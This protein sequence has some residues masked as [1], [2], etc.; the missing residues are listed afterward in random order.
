MTT[1][2][3][4]TDPKR[5]AVVALKEAETEEQ[6]RMA[7]ASLLKTYRRLNST[8]DMREIEQQENHNHD[9][10][11]EHIPAIIRAV[12]IAAIIG[13]AGWV[14]SQ[15]ARLDDWEPAY[16]AIK[17]RQEI[18]LQR[19]DAIEASQHPATS[20]RYTADDANRDR[21]ANIREHQQLE[22]RILRLEQR[23]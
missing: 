20:R 19:L 4:C 13:L 3:D 22:Q 16:S 6:E 21:E 5:C 12:V 2:E 10:R 23:K 7:L 15:E 8:H 17:A 11:D 14:L 9:E 18:V 1:A